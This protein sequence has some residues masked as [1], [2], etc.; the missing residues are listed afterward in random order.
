MPG[1]FE[2]IITIGNDCPNLGSKDILEAANILGEKD[3]VFGPSTDGGV[4][5]LGLNRKVFDPYALSQISW[6][7]EKVFEELCGLA[8]IGNIHFLPFK[9]D[10]DNQFDLIQVLYSL[11]KTHWLV[12][13]INQLMNVPLLLSFKNRVINSD[14]KYTLTCPLRG[15]P[16]YL[17]P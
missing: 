3:W 10:I 17:F 15:P 2:R 6:E 16:S 14:Q 4:Y 1:D 8:K 13:L 11:E 5:L 7:T 9:A 12:V